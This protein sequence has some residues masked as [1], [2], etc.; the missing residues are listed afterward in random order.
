[1]SPLFEEII[2]GGAMWSMTIPRHRLVRLTALDAGA[3]AAALLFN[4]RQPLDRLNVPDTL[5]ALHTAKLTRGHVLMSDMGHA[6]ASIVDDTLDWHDPLGGCS[7]ADHMRDKYGGHTYQDFRNDWHRNARD[8]FLIELGKHGLGLRDL[9]A[10]VNFFSKVV[11]NG[12]GVM[13]FAPGHCHSGAS[14]TLRTEMETL[15]VLSNTPHPLAPAGEYPRVDVKIEIEPANPPSAD[16]FCRNFRPEC[17][18][19]LSLTERLHI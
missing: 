10:N 8:N 12:D 9:V 18:R 6:L 13:H 1:M 15:L 14:L 4:A 7:T 3:N 2:P 11:V 17:A 16:D 19:A 5:K